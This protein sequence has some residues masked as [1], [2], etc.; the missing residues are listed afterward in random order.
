MRAGRNHPGRGL[1]FGGD[2]QDDG[3]PA[4][5]GCEKGAGG[6]AEE[7]LPAYRIV[8]K[9]NDKLTSEG[10]IIVPGK[11]AARYFYEHIYI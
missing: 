10:K 6:D 3:G 2:R 4:P 9:L 8:K 5:K 1:S 11:I 7:A